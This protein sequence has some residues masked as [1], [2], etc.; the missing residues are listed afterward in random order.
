MDDTETSFADLYARL[1]KTVALL[2]DARRDRFAAPDTP[3]EVKMGPKTAHF[4]ALGYV[5]KFVLP[6]YFFH[7]MATYAILRKEGVPVGKVDYLGADVE[8]WKM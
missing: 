3:V 6:N 7:H 1:D 2:R 8:E 5:Q 4:D